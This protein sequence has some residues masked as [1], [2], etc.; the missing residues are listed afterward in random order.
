MPPIIRPLRLAAE[1]RQH[2]GFARWVLDRRANAAVR[3]DIGT[4]VPESGEVLTPREVEILRLVAAGTN[5]REIAEHLVVSEYTAK[6]YLYRIFRKLESTLEHRQRLG[7]DSWVLPESSGYYF[8]LTTA[9]ASVRLDRSQPCVLQHMFFLSRLFAGLRKSPNGVAAPPDTTL[10][11]IR[12][13]SACAD[14]VRA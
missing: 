7:R 10:P 5:N 3:H 9:Y 13:P 1:G 12:A 2:A 4:R 6:T 14:P 8:R 11:A